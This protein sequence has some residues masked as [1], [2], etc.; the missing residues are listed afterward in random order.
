[1]SAS[2]I[3]PALVW[4][5]RVSIVR[6]RH[7]GQGSSYKEKHLIGAGLQFQ[8][9]SPFSSWQIAWQHPGRHGAGERA[10][11]SI[12]I[13]RQQKGIVSHRQQKGRLSSTLGRAW[14]KE[15]SN[16][17]PTMRN[18]LQLGHIYSNKGTP[19]NNSTCYGQALKHMIYG[20]QTYSNHHHIWQAQF[21]I[22]ITW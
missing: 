6:K 20:G 14:A 21:R 18:F 17:T 1:M 12:L 9:F 16:P 15:T 11:L 2:D 7:H 13:R 4:C 22:F 8:R 19:P 3:V 5:H 10:E